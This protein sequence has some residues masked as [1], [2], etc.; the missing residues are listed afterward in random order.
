M[1][2]SMSHRKSLLRACSDVQRR[3]GSRVSIR[4]SKS[5]AVVGK[6][7]RR[8]RERF[9]NCRN[10]WRVDHSYFRAVQ[11][12]YIQGKLFPQPSS[13]LLLGFHGVEE[14][15]FNDVRPDCRTGT[16]AQTAEGHGRGRHR[17]MKKTDKCVKVD[18]EVITSVLCSGEGSLPDQL[19]L[20]KLL[21]S[22]EDG[23]LGKQ[24]SQ[25]TPESRQR[26]CRG[27][28]INLH[29]SNLN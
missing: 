19:Q 22:L 29:R 4:S 3:A 6:L 2:G 7:H 23:L 17:V 11:H 18:A 27:K 14:G 26:M 28:R 13:V 1:L 9:F 24:L 8:E 5:R 15:K 25:N 20:Q 12:G 16:P 21:V 10:R